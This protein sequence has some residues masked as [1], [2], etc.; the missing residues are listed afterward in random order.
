[1]ARV[2]YAAGGRALL[3]SE[4]IATLD[5]A[6][7]SAVRG[8]NGGGRASFS[9]TSQQERAMSAHPPPVPPAQRS[10]KGPGPADAAGTAGKTGEAPAQEQNLAEQGRQGAKQN[11]TNKGFQQDR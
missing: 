11:T 1:M 10:T 4:D 5:H 2:L 9:H 6:G 3:Q 8:R 7:A